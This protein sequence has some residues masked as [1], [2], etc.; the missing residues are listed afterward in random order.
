MN[1]SVQQNS[2][3]GVTGVG[4]TALWVA[5]LRTIASSTPNPIIKDE[6]SKSLAGKEGFEILHKLDG[7]N[8]D[9]NPRVSS[10]AKR[11]FVLDLFINEAIQNIKQIVNLGSGLDTK[12]YRLNFP[13]DVVFYEIDVAAVTNYKKRILNKINATPNCKLITIAMD[14]TKKDEWVSQLLQSGFDK[15]KPSL[16]ITEG[17]LYYLYDNDVAN[18]LKS[19][20]TLSAI[21]SIFIGDML[22]TFSYFGP[23]FRASREKFRQNGF[24]VYSHSNDMRPILQK[25]GFE[26]IN[27]TYSFTSPKKYIETDPSKMDGLYQFIGLKKDINLIKCNL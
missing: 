19:I 21:G 27:V 16:F 20:S 6:F 12:P 24:D 18:I 17:L 22:S 25:Y 13:S 8:Y 3:S 26:G 2:D 11:T 10:I 5:A 23:R 1:Q 14:L 9:Q 7:T 4:V 15:N